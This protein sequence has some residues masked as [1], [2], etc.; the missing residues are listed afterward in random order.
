MNTVRT[1]A[2]TKAAFLSNYPRPINS[3]YRRAVEEILIDLHL[4]TVSGRFAYNPFFA[5]GLTTV[6]DTFMQGYVPPTE[7]PK[8]FEAVCKALLLKPEVIRDDAGKLMAL[9]QSG[10]RQQRLGALQLK[11]DAE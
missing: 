2:S 4:V 10:D 5:L 8:I 9:M 3:F 11:D 6:Y 1:V 7:T